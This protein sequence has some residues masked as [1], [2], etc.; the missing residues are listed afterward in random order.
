MF[1]NAG[2]DPDHESLCFIFITYSKWK[3]S[4]KFELQ[5]MNIVPSCIGIGGQGSCSAGSGM[6]GDLLKQ[7]HFLGEIKQ[8]QRR[9]V[10]FELQCPRLCAI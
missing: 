2:S 10:I 7:I 4:K 1:V 5:C 6:S 3:F 8:K 9:H